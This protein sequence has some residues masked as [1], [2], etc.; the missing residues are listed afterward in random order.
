MNGPDDVF[1]WCPLWEE[2]EDVVRATIIMVM[3]VGLYL[4]L[5]LPRSVD[6]YDWRKL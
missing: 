1:G 5:A 2:I 6:Y 4:A 3:F